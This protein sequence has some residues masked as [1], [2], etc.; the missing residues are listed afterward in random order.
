MRACDNGTWLDGG[1]KRIINCNC[2]C[3]AIIQMITWN[4]SNLRPSSRD[5]TFLNPLNAELNPI[6]NLL[7]LLGD[8]TFMGSCIV[9]IFQYTCTVYPT[10]CNVTQ[11]IYIWKLLYMF[12]VVLPHI[13]RSAYNCIYS[14]WY[15]SRRYCYLPLSW[16]VG[17]GLSVLWVAYA[18]HS[19]T[20]TS[21]CRYSCMRFWWCVEVPPETCKAVSRYK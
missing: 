4:L 10:R 1:R 14:I 3:V 15:L 2:S 20:N 17:T 9:S 19:V 5:N 13:I 8:L 21:C 11:F 6:C 16:R 12:R 7:V 18:T